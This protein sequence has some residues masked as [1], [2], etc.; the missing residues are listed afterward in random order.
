MITHQS[1]NQWLQDYIAAWK[2]YNPQAI[3]ALFSQ[4]AV[5]RYN[6]YDAGMRGRDQIVAGWLNDRDE[7]NTYSA[8]YEVLAVDGNTA[9]TQGRSL[10]YGADGKTVKRQFDN[11]FVL[12][13]DDQG[14]CTDFCEWWMV[15]RG[16]S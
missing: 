15:P 2:S 9:V 16:Q 8:E 3:G 1:V 11:I 14:R 4:D 7:A 6:P 13:F 5:Y 12:K 10:Y